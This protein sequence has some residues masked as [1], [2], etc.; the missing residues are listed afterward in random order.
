MF[1]KCVSRILSMLGVYRH[2]PLGRQTP[3]RHPPG[4]TFSWANTPPP[5]GYCSGR[6]ASYWNTFLLDL[7]LILIVSCFEAAI[8]TYWWW[9]GVGAV[10]STEFEHQASVKLPQ[11]R[12]FNNGSRICL[13]EEEGY[14][15]LESNIYYIFMSREAMPKILRNFQ[16]RSLKFMVLLS[17]SKGWGRPQSPPPTWISYWISQSYNIQFSLRAILKDCMFQIRI[18]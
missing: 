14:K 1:Y 5:D 15:F 11:I 2:T 8:V 12:T 16:I 9:I 18:I 7:L 17:K 10:V 3:G 6:Y 4:Q 13:G